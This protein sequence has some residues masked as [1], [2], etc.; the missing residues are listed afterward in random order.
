M[1]IEVLGTGCPKC[2]SM[3]QNVR[4]ALAELQVQA[5][6]VKV[7]EINDMLARGVMWTPALVID[8]KIVLQG[9][10]PTV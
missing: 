9:K 1:K 7:T 4:K 10:I 8:G 3:E 5:E 2:Q 6:V